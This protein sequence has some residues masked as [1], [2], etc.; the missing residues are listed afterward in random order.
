M[1]LKY[2]VNYQKKN[3]LWSVS[4][5]IH[6]PHTLNRNLGVNI[7]KMYNAIL[8]EKRYYSKYSWNIWCDYKGKVKIVVNIPKI[9]DA[10]L[11]EKW[12]YSK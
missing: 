7:R 9:Y 2:E 3:V 1:I 10:I 11:T 8:T 12:N 4:H 6:E 5:Q